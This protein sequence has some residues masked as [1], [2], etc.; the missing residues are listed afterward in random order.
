MT[1]TLLQVRTYNPVIARSHQSLHDLATYVSPLPGPS[2]RRSPSPLPTSSSVK[3]TNSPS[4]ITLKR[5]ISQLHTLNILKSN[6]IRRL[7][8]E[9]WRQ[10]KKISSLKGLV[11][12][13]KNKNLMLEEHENIIFEHFGENKNIIQRLF[14]KTQNKGVRNMY[15]HSIRAF[16]TTLHFFSPKAYNYVRQKFYNSLPHPKTLAK[17]Y[18]AID[19]KPGFTVE[20]I[21]FLKLKVK[22]SNKQLYCSLVFDE[23]AIRKHLEYSGTEYYGYVDYGSALHG[24]SMELASEALVFMIVCINEPWKLPIG[25]FFISGLNSQ[26]KTALVKQALTLLKEIEINVTNITFDGCVANFS[27]CNLL[28]CR[29]DRSNLKADFTFNDSKYFLLPDPVHMIKLIRNCFG[30]KK[31]FINVDGEC[32]NFEFIEK[33]NNLQEQE[34]LHL[35]TKLRKQHVNFLKQKMKVRLATQLL[36]R[37][38]S[39]A[40]FYCRDKL[41]L[42]EFRNC[43]PTADFIL[44]MNNVFD[45]LNSHKISDFGF[46]QATCSNNIE[47]IRLFLFDFSR[48]INNLKF[49]DGTHVLLSQRKSGFVGL[50]MGLKAVIGIYDEYI[51]K[52]HLNFIPT[53]KLN[54]DHIELFF[55]TIRSQGGYNNNPTCRQ[56]MAAYKKILIHAEV[57]EGGAGN[58]IPLEDI[59]ILNVTSRTKPP[60]QIINESVANR[61]LV[62]C[63]DDAATHD[64]LNDHNY[65]FNYDSLSAYSVEVVTYIAGFVSFKLGNKLQCELCV[66]QLYGDKE[67]FLDS[68]ISHKSRGGLKYPSTDVLV[69]CIKTEKFLKVESIHKNKI[70]KEIICLKILNYFIQEKIFEHMVCHDSS[71]IESHKVLLIKAVCNCYLTTRINYMCKN[72][73]NEEKIRNMYTKLILFKG[74]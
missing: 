55:G 35:G 7:Q 69:I 28:N 74:Q 63:I 51:A 41:Q 44:I 6:K 27:M 4:K 24:D 12:E 73:L 36:S 16:A 68:L 37:S 43:G 11:S 71:P 1:V 15:D 30:E 70:N 58:C 67:D 9:N 5:K 46:K 14:Q 19:G 61:S 62:N 29:F 3:T 60:E 72:T 18:S 22:H 38:V 8:K 23:I 34:G 13:L 48:Y 45:I 57:R 17:W 59:N 49:L 54:Q 33:L 10:K 50:L 39:E 47:N 26:Q 53:Y 25:Y 52:G 40:L 2:N 65:A 21:N 42:K 20:A 64:F 31:K 56:F 32:I 66:T